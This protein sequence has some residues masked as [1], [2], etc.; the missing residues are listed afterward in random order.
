[1][2][3]KPSQTNR[4]AMAAIDAMPFQPPATSSSP[5]SL[6]AP[7][8][9]I[10]LFMRSPRRGGGNGASGWVSVSLV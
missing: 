7:P 10:S 9:M 8:A 3:T 6:T 1:M 5:C 4:A 2:L